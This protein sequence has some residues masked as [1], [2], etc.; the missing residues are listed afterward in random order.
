MDQAKKLFAS[1]DP[2]FLAVDPPLELFE[3]EADGARI[4][5]YHLQFFPANGILERAL[6]FEAAQLISLLIRQESLV[7]ADCDGEHTSTISG[8]LD[9]VKLQ[10]TLNKT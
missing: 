4:E 3:F 6:G 7:H 5:F 9:I 2:V 8:L 10:T 1:R